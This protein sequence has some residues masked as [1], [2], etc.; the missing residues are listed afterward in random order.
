VLVPVIIDP[1]SFDDLPD[2]ELPVLSALHKSS[3]SSLLRHGVVVFPEVEFETSVAQAIMKLPQRLRESWM[4]ALPAML[5]RTSPSATFDMDAQGLPE[6]TPELARE[7]RVLACGVTLAGLL[8]LRIEDSEA[9]EVMEVARLELLSESGAFHDAASL[10]S[11]DILA[12]EN[13]VD[14]WR[15]RFQPLAEAVR[16]ATIVDRYALKEFARHRVSGLIWAAQQLNSSTVRNLTVITGARDLEEFEEL[17]PD[18]QQTF[19]EMNM[20]RGSLRKVTWSVCID[21]AFYGAHGRYIRFGESH[22]V[23]V[24]P[25]FDVFRTNSM[26]QTFPCPRVDIASQLARESELRSKRIDRME[27]RL[28]R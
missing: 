20:G 1:G 25:G 28:D 3:I 19:R 12:G 9:E 17:K 23:L 15:E 4:A 10:N 16:T 11:R 14:V 24:E 2:I 18:L 8:Q 6:M 26:R 5:V 27:I 21:Q 22:C 7:V 13:R